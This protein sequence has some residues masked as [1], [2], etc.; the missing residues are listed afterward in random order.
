MK[1][2]RPPLDPADRELF[3]DA[4][5]AVRPLAKQAVE[6]R[7]TPPRAHPTQT[8]RDAAAVVRELAQAPLSALEPEM[9]D[10][11][12]YL[13]EGMPPQTL[14]KLGRGEFALRDELDLHHMTAA[15]ATEAI[16]RFLD[17]CRRAGRLCVRIIHG[18]G[19]RSKAQGPVLK[20]LTDR[21]LR[22]RGDVLAFRSA[23]AADGGSGAVVVLLRRDR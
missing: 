16:A 21:L 5:G 6:R 15:V 3:R 19:L 2:E 9:S 22:R 1:R 8:L 4:V 14:R 13:R 20:R 23:R 17:E 18:K 12:S 11:L 10:P 7:P